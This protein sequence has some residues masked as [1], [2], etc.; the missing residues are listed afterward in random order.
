MLVHSVDDEIIGF[1]HAKRLSDNAPAGHHF[2]PI[3]GAHS[4]GHLTSGA[5]YAEPLRKFLLDTGLTLMRDAPA[6]DVQRNV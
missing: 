6:Q 2:V 1:D 5:A 4:G 3:S